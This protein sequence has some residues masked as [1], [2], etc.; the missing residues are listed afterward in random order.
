[1]STE[2]H[3]ITVGGL[4]VDVVRKEIKNLHLGVYPP[5]GRV[6]VA[7][8]MA[9]SDEAVRLAVIARMGWI[10]RQRA[11]FV[12]QVRQT[13]RAYVS[14]ESHFFLGRRYRLNLIDGA[15]A[16]RVQIRNARSLDLNVRAGSEQAVR[17]RVF[18]RW[19]R[20]ELRTRA[21]PL[22]EKWAAAMGLAKPAWGI[23]RMKTKWGTCNVASRRIWLNLELIKKPPQGLEYVIVHELAHLLERTHSDRF[24]AIMDAHLPQWRHLRA[25][26]NAETLAHEIWSE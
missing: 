3:H 20:E 18:L 7:A 22:V 6:R 25:E 16:G 15:G 10:K 24:T 1:V 8:P 5:E 21:A 11:K 12:T 17:E 2:A 4:H 13:E 23:K 9:V 26:L 19:Y 14:G